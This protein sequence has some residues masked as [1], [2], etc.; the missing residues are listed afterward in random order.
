MLESVQSQLLSICLSPS[1]TPVN[2]YYVTNTLYTFTLV[3]TENSLLCHI[4]FSLFNA[5]D[6]FPILFYISLSL[7]QDLVIVDTKYACELL[8]L[9]D[10][11]FYQLYRRIASGFE[12][13]CL[14]FLVFL[15]LIF[16]QPLSKCFPQLAYFVLTLFHHA[17]IMLDINAIPPV[18]SNSYVM[19]I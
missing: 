1:Y 17:F 9:L 5:A 6:A 3:L 2:Q 4:A 19:T 18:K 8:H 11:F 14:G 10:F 13:H 7:P 16:S 15:A 12:S